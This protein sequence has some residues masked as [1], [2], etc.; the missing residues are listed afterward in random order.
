MPG[1]IFECHV[2]KRTVRTHSIAANPPSLDYP[3]R[4]LKA[5]KPV[6]VQVFIPQFSIKTFNTSIRDKRPML[7]RKISTL[8]YL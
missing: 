3:T 1:K 6:F 8:P 7:P 2:V 4:L 5:C